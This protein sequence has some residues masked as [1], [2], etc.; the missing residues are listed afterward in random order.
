MTLLP[1][2]AF[3]QAAMLRGL[4][5]WV[6]IESPT[7]APEAVNRM[8]SLA[9]RQLAEIGAMIETVPGRDNFG[10]TVLARFA[11]KVGAP[12]ILVLIHLDTVH[13]LGTIDRA[14]PVRVEGD[15]CY[16]P[17]IYDMKGGGFIALEAMRQLRRADLA[18][19]LPVTFMLI[20]DEEVGSPS[21]RALIEAEARRH[22]HVLVPE[23]AQDQGRLITGRWAFARF[24]LNARGRP[25]HAGANTGMGR[26]AIREMAEQI[27]RIERLSR[28]ADNV[29]FSVGVIQGGTFV[30]VVPLECRAEVLAI[31]PDNRQ[32]DWICRTMLA[33]E[34]VGEGVS[35]RVTQGP[36]RPLFEGGAG[37]MAIYGLASSLAARIGF[38]VGHGSVGGG[39]DGNFTGALGIPTLDGLGLCGDGFHTHGEHILVSS[40]V[41]RAQ[42][43]AG[44]LSELR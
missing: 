40:L 4:V 21:T 6:S 9:A 20:P 27:L 33:L 16:G 10:D 11:G 29:T 17:G 42:I 28:P 2:T 32:L 19:E 1:A 22:A 44:L 18:P 41:P 30:N 23:P 24:V 25:A 34:P 31:A 12:G 39:S 7:N 43:F 26:S 3:D 8:M 5:E 36:I 15:R 35:F 14:L 38:E 13:P 37:T